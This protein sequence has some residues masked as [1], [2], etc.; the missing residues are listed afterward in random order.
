MKKI[1]CVATAM[2]CGWLLNA[3]GANRYWVSAS[4]S[5]WNLAANWS[6]TSNGVGGV[7]VPGT[8]DSVYFTPSANGNCQIDL[9]PVTIG[10][11]S[12]NGYTGHLDG[13]TLNPDVTVTGNVTF[14]SGNSGTNS[15]GRGTWTIGGSFDYSAMGSGTGR[16]MIPGVSTVV[17]TGTNVSLKAVYTMTLCNLM[18][19]SNAVVTNNGTSTSYLMVTNNMDVYGTII[20]LAN[21]TRIQPNRLRVH[22]SGRVTGSGLIYL[23]N[24][25]GIQLLEPG[26][27]VDLDTIQFVSDNTTPGYIVPGHYQATNLLFWGETYV[28]TWKMTNGVYDIDGSIQLLQTNEAGAVTLDCTAAVVRVGGNLT[29][30]RNAGVVTNK[31]RFVGAV[32]LTGTKDRVVDLNT[33]PQQPA[34]T[35]AMSAGTVTLMSGVSNASLTVTGGCL[36][37]NGK[38]IRTTGN[39]TIGGNAQVTGSGLNGSAVTVGGNLDVS[40]GGGAPLDL[41]ATAPWTLSVTG[42][43][44]ASNVNVS[45]SDASGGST[46]RAVNSTDGGNNT[47][48]QFVSGGTTLPVVT[49]LGVTVWRLTADLQAQVTDTG[50]DTPSAWFRY[51]IDGQSTTTTVA[52]GLQGATFSTTLSGLSVGSNYSYVVVVSNSAG[53]ASSAVKTFTPSDISGGQSTNIYWVSSAASAWSNAANWATSSNGVGGVGLPGTRDN[54]YFTASENGNCRIDINPLT[55]GSVSVNG[56]TGHLDAATYNPDVTVTGNVTFASGVNGTNSLGNGTWT[57]GGSFDYSGMGASNRKLNPNSST[58]VMTGMNVGIKAN[59]YQSLWNLSIA[60]NAVVTN[61]GESSSTYINVSSN[62]DIYGSL[63]LGYANPLHIHVFATGRLTGAGG[64]GLS[65]SIQFAPG[66]VIDLNSIELLRPIGGNTLPPGHYQ[67]TN[68][69]VWGE[70]YTTTWYLTNGVYNIDGNIQFYQNN[71]AGAATLDCT[72]SSINVGGSLSNGM[73]AAV[74]TNKSRFLGGITLT[75]VKDRYVNLNT[76]PQQP[77]LTMAMSAGTVTLLSGV[78]NAAVTVTGGCLNVNG[79]PIRTSGNLTIG[80]DAQVVGS[81]LNGSVI[82]VGGNLS[83]AGKPDSLLDLQATATWMLS[84][85]GSGTAGNVNVS[86]S[87]ASGGSTIM[88]FYSRD[89]GHNVNWLFQMGS[90][91]TIR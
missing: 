45:Y 19:A 53:G 76:M 77:A 82:T 11:L 22:S 46:I 54:V 55:I 16:A 58:V 7:G 12:V 40:G 26:S 64:V 18:I 59:Y 6:G 73:N 83:L 25:Y 2:L 34:L 5:T 74:V 63:S 23:K 81:G 68:L 51:W 36:N 14:A 91:F 29:N 61:N 43:G 49:N 50:G 67:M 41:H 56:Y 30:I 72:A 87:D 86:Y 66:G 33:M 39:L 47:N 38:P 60:S 31:S 10:L 75:G 8:G 27:V 44:A 90:V 32:T 71:E 4:A 17:M 85:V 42:S 37:V 78:S 15:L 9:N 35:M 24:S 69:V 79:K 28:K 89:S 3:H 20:S 1:L 52:K 13:A 62:L 88:A 84:V 57:I 70:T 48:W 65:G 80:G 21:A